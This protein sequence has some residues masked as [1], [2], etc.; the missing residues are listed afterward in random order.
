[1]LISS[2]D[3]I[4]YCSNSRRSDLD[5]LFLLPFRCL[6]LSP[7]HRAALSSCGVGDR[8]VGSPLVSTSWCGELSCRPQEAGGIVYCN[9]WRWGAHLVDCTAPCSRGRY[10]VA[11]HGRRS[12][13]AH[14]VG[15]P[16]SH[17][18]ASRW[19]DFGLLPWIVDFDASVYS[20]EGAD[21]GNGFALHCQARVDNLNNQT[22]CCDRMQVGNIVIIACRTVA[23]GLRGGDWFILY[24]CKAQLP[25][26]LDPTSAAVRSVIRGYTPLVFLRVLR[27]VKVVRPAAGTHRMG[28][29]LEC[30][31]RQ[32][33][34]AQTY[35]LE[36]SWREIVG[37]LRG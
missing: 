16:L 23:L 28:P 29:V 19:S 9:L 2:L 6:S 15:V 21:R 13:S 20:T 3:K 12:Q 8:C 11:W 25:Y 33:R 17:G 14:F 26:R 1:M 34:V 5:P 24:T 35:V 30:T 36:T 31:Y 4:L 22:M 7:Y 10:R 27:G 18:V 32:G 37:L